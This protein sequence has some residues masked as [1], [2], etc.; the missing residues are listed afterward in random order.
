MVK[1]YMALIPLL[2]IITSVVCRTFY[3]IADK[4]TAIQD[5]TFAPDK[6]PR[7]KMDR[8]NL[9][10]GS[11]LAIQYFIMIQA[12]GGEAGKAS[13]YF[14]VL[15]LF[16]PG[17]FIIISLL[18]FIVLA[19][20][21]RGKVLFALAGIRNMLYG[22]IGLYLSL[23]LFFRLLHDRSFIFA[24]FP[25]GF[26]AIFWAGLIVTLLYDVF[27]YKIYHRRSN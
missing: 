10:H 7:K 2:G 3:R 14:S 18:V 21:R 26:F 9:L 5:K 19:E 1:S 15:A 16:L 22:Y 27:S 11:L 4:N 6:Y 12:K 24:Q 25:T 23:F 8:M 17:V 13:G 20:G